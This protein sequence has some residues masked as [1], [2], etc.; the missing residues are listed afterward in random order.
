MRQVAFLMEGARTTITQHQLFL[1][2]LTYAALVIVFLFLLTRTDRFSYCHYSCRARREVE[3][4]DAGGL[5]LTYQVFRGWFA[6][7]AITQQRVDPQDL[8]LK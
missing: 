6:Q 4:G 3:N 2:A 1:C 7:T 5:T 8:I